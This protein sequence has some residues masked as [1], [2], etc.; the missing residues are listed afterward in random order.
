MKKSILAVLLVLPTMA[1]ALDAKS[2]SERIAVDATEEFS[3]Q[4]D[5]G[6]AVIN[7]SSSSSVS[8]QVDFMPDSFSG[9]GPSLKDYED[10]GASYDKATKTLTIRCGQ[11]VRAQVRI[12]LPVAQTA[13][14]SLEDGIA[15]I[16]AHAGRLKAFVR[17]GMIRFDGSA[18]PAKACVVGVA[19]HGHVS[20]SRGGE[21]MDPLVLLRVT[22]GTISVK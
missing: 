14:L 20:N 1:S 16:G 17:N 22:N 11:N 19:K 10:S 8:Y 21:C 18:L 12:G 5:K 9:R 4:I 3:I 13:S 2:V 15:E 7:P 6:Q